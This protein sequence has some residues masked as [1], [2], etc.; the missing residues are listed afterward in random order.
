MVVLA[1][2]YP[3]GLRAFGYLSFCS[4]MSQEYE[5]PDWTPA[6]PEAHLVAVREAQAVLAQCAEL[7]AAQ[8][9]H[10]RELPPCFGSAG[11]LKRALSNLADTEDAFCGSSAFFSGAMRSSRRPRRSRR[12]RTR[13]GRWLRVACGARL[14]WLKGFE[15]THLVGLFEAGREANR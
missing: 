1:P 10:Q 12:N 9:G 13:S 6:A 3:C 14:R 8:Q 2:A 4:V 15:V 7:V 11:R 5:A